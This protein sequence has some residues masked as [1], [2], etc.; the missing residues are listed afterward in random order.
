MAIADLM[1]LQAPS[2]STR[3]TVRYQAATTLIA[4]PQITS[5]VAPAGDEDMD[6]VRVHLRPAVAGLLRQQR[7]AE[8]Q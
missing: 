2:T 7:E 4:T 6:E 5:N 1:D 3:A 8:A